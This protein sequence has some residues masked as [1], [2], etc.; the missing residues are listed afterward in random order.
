MCFW[1][2]VSGSMDPTQIQGTLKHRKKRTRR[3]KCS[4]FEEKFR[5]LKKSCD[6]LKTAVK[7]KA[8]RS[9]SDSH[10]KSSRINHWIF[11]NA[12]QMSCE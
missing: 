2:F 8:S 7:Y 5:L 1:E 9:S 11:N 4:G 6:K 3:S 12:I 10:L